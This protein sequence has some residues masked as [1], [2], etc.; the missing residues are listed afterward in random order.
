MLL[1]LKNFLAIMQE[2][3]YHKIE[4]VK[5]WKLINIHKSE[6]KWLRLAIKNNNTEIIE[7]VEKI[8]RDF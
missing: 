5:K 4:V 2:I 3:W 1:F 6:W 7:K 8:I